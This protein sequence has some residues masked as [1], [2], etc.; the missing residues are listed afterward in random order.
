MKKVLL[1]QFFLIHL[2]CLSIGQI[3][4]IAMAENQKFHFE[5]NKFYAD[6]SVTPLLNEDLANFK[7]L[8][9]FEIDLSYRVIA[10]LTIDSLATEFEMKT[11]TDRK[12]KYK[13]FGDLHFILK[14]QRFVVPVYQNINLLKDTAYSDY[15]FFPFTDLTSGESTYGGGRYIDV[16]RND[17]NLIELDFNQCYQPY[18]AYNHKYSCPIPPAE[19]HLNIEI[20]AGVKEGIILKNP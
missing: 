3:D 6:S 14:N 13:K 10:K 15:L 17:Q 7:S 12:P 18:C 9:F 8:S 16:K 5:M 19:N 11:S 2:I 1:I 4:S 20:R